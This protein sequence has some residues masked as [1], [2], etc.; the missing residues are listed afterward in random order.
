VPNDQKKVQAHCDEL[1]EL[2]AL[3]PGRNPEMLAKSLALVH[4]LRAAAEWDFPQHLLRDLKER[5]TIWFIDRAWRGD[6][7]EFHG[8]LVRDVEQLCAAWERP[9]T[10]QGH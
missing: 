7:A 9:K 10:L 3:G 6:T 5:L 8:A 4:V 1:R 2:I